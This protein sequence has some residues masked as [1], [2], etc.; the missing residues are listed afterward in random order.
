MKTLTEVRRERRE[1]D[2]QLERLR[3]KLREGGRNVGATEAAIERRRV[4]L[5]EL[6]DLERELLSAKSAHDRS[7]ALAQI[8]TEWPTIAERIERG[9]ALASVRDFIAESPIHH[10]GGKLIEA[11]DELDVEVARG[12]FDDPA[13]PLADYPPAVA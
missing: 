11:L 3:A 2:R 13:V 7:P 5:V 12:D 6:C 9:D 8:R 4:R 1:N 10:Y